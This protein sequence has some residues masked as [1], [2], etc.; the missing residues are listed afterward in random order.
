M[1]NN[2]IGQHVKELSYKNENET[3][4][5]HWDKRVKDLDFKM[6]KRV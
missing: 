2:E 4:Y 6:D 3:K 1:G 5:K